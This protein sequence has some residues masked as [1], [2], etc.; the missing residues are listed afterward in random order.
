MFFS[1]FWENIPTINWLKKTLVYFKYSWTTLLLWQELPAIWK[2]HE[3]TC[4]PSSID[5]SKTESWLDPSLRSISDIMFP[6]LKMWILSFYL[7]SKINCMLYSNCFNYY[8]SP[9]QK[10]NKPIANRVGSKN[11]KKKSEKSMYL[12]LAHFGF[13]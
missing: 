9:K 12:V 8:S 1:L 4:P 10:Q 11:K 13:Y 2:Q 7:N 5:C 3:A 6:F